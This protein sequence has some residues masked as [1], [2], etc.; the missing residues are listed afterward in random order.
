M[1]ATNE[2]EKNKTQQDTLTQIVPSGK[3]QPLHQ[4]KKS[5]REV[6][7]FKYSRHR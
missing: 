3:I 2:R 7:Q 6:S 4:N 5:L 1:L